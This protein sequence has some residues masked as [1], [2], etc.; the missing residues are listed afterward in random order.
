MKCIH[1][2]KTVADGARFCKYCGTQLRRICSVCGAG[3]DEDARFCAEC[4]AEALAELDLSAKLPA[5]AG[6]DGI[7]PTGKPNPYGFYFSRRLSRVYRG[8]V[9]NCFS[10]CGDAIAFMEEHTLNRLTPTTEGI[11]R[12]TSDVSHDNAVMAVA[13][14]PDGSICT[15]GLDWAAGSAPAVTVW[16]YDVA[17]NLRGISEVLRLNGNRAR[18]TIKLRLTDSSLFIFLWDEH[19][20]GKREIVKYSLDGG[21]KLEQKQLEGERIDLWY[22]DGERVYFRGQNGADAFFGVL[23]TAAEPWA[24]RRL[25]TFGNGPDEIP[26]APVYCD[27]E[28][29]IAWTAATADERREF[30]LAEKA[31]VARTLGPGHALAEGYASWLYQE[32]GEASFFF[33]YFD[34]ERAYKS[35]TAITIAGLDYTAPHRWRNTL[36][37]DTENVIVWGEYLLADLTGHGY[38]IYPA[39]LDGPADVVRDGLFV[40]EM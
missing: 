35:I 19:D 11:V 15:A 24:V 31:C 4:G 21:G 39:T 9:D 17:L 20:A 7:V 5:L 32:T 2:G 26:D 30:G 14:A 38:R 25:W 40:K 10:I 28:K 12:R 33:D 27:F 37:G 16:R 6:N 34:G 23:D 29:G 3:L 36:H 22:A 18:Q 8:T 13:L 1:C